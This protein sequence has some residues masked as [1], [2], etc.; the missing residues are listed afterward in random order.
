[1]SPW[2]PFRS[3]P[4]HNECF[5]HQTIFPAPMTTFNFWAEPSVLEALSLP[6]V[7]LLLLL[8]RLVSNFWAPTIFLPSFLSSSNYRHPTPT[9]LYFQS[10]KEGWFGGRGRTWRHRSGGRMIKLNEKKTMLSWCWESNPAFPICQVG[11]P[12][13]CYIPSLR[14]Y[15]ILM[16]PA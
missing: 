8:L 15:F 7:D 5:A 10:E 3:S 1:M 6:P 11:A 14:T 4:L 2:P 12:P 9:S 13:P 16:M